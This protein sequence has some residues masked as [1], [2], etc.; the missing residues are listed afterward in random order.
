MRINKR[1][2]F[3]AVLATL[4]TVTVSGQ[5]LAQGYPAR[6]VTAVIQWGAGGAHLRGFS[7]PPPPAGRAPPRAGSEL[8][9]AIGRR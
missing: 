4:A 9:P 5:A 3:G 1:Q 6:D 8:A 7:R 2:W